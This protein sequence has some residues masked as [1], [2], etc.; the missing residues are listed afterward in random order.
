MAPLLSLTPPLDKDQVGWYDMIDVNWLRINDDAADDDNVN[1]DDN[2]DNDG[3]GDK[4]GNGD[5]LTRARWAP[6]AGFG[7][8]LQAAIALKQHIYILC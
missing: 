3:N 7:L 8:E 1:N 4:D 2:V 6:A 5:A